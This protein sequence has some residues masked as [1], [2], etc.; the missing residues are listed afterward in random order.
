MPPPN[1]PF[2]LDLSGIDIRF[3]AIGTRADNVGIIGFNARRYITNKRSYEVFL[4]VQNF[5][6]RA[7]TRE[8]IL[9][10]EGLP[11]DVRSISMGPGERKRMIYPDLS[12]GEGHRLRATLHPSPQKESQ[13]VFPVDDQA[14]AL[15]PDQHKLRVLLVTKDNLYLEGALL[16]YDTIEID[17]VSPQEY[18]S[19][20]DQ[21]SKQYNAAI[22]DDYTPNAA[23]ATHALYFNPT[24]ENSPFPIAR[25]L[26]RPRITQVNEDHPVMRWIVLGDVNVDKA[27]VFRPLVAKGDSVLAKS[28]RAPLVV[29]R[30]KGPH[31]AIAV[32]FSLSGTDLTMRV[33][34]PLFLV[35]ALDW[36][37]G[38]SSDLIATYQTGKRYLVTAEAATPH[39]QAQ[40]HSPV[41][42]MTRTPITP[43]GYAIFYS[44]EVGIHTMTISSPSHP[45]K[46][47]ELAANLA[48]AM[49]SNIAPMRAFH[50]GG[51]TIPPTSGIKGSRRQ[52]VWLYLAL[53]ALVLLG[54]SGP[55][56]IVVLPCDACIPCYASLST[57]SASVAD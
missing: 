20:A 25:N 14:Y 23:P 36:F 52:S 47:T 41:G 35:N 44:T 19:N 8:L 48:N 37:S 22:F 11:I 28:I 17:K 38:D 9:S 16:A 1:N 34:F 46:S 54:S 49:E 51:R 27:S 2:S 55:P 56:I 6:D 26:Q 43:E 50:L 42:R 57:L 30:H 5:G 10:N 32:G 33:A 3:L 45:F 7:S 29:A 21:Y 18:E 24:G 53:A 31:K 12:G 40:I 13:D 15:L 4:E 39:V